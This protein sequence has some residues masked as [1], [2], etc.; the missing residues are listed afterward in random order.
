MS[1]L[2]KQAKEFGKAIQMDYSV[3][4]GDMITFAR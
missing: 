1:Q 4:K 3:S 2:S